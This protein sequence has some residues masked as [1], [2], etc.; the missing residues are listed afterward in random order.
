VVVTALDDRGALL[1][2]IEAG[3]DDIVAKPFDRIELRA[4]IRATTRL[5][6]YRRLVGE[7]DKFEWV[8]ELSDDGYLVVEASGA[9]SYANPRAVLPG[10]RLEG[11]LDGT[12]LFIRIE[13]G[14]S[15][16]N[17]AEVIALAHANLFIE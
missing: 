15:L 17:A 1:E 8:V 14:D 9:I 12:F 6:R 7:R 13:N 16:L 4:R 2:G 11:Q 5:N 3:A 10:A